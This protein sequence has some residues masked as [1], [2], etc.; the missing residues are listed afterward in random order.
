MLPGIEAAVAAM[1]QGETRTVVLEPD[2]AYGERDESMVVT[3]PRDDIEA[4]SDA[5]A[6]EG[7]LVRSEAGDA[8][9]VVDVTDD[10][11]TVDFNHELAGERVAFDVHLL[12][13]HA[14]ETGHPEGRDRSTGTS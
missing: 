1:D 11:V 14:S 13:V 10:A 5:T 7:A 3:V 12:E 2:E 4:R 6:E 8:G 9:W